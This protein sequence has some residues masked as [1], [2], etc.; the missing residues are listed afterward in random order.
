[1]ADQDGAGRQLGEVNA[2]VG[3]E[4]LDFL[5]QV[6]RTLRVALAAVLAERTR[7]GT[8][9]EP[10]SPNRGHRT[11]V[12]EPWSPN[13]VVTGPR[14]KGMGRGEIGLEGEIERSG[15]APGLSFNRA[16]RRLAPP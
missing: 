1:V 10:W 15:R 14:A 11:V 5:Q 6:T 7:S 2:G 4:R 3:V 12:T 16:P 8:V 9:T 13:R